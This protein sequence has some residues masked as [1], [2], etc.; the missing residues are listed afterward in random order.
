LGEGAK[1]MSQP[2]V[3]K[4]SQVAGSNHQAEPEVV[5]RAQRR[6]VSEAEKPRILTEAAACQGAGALGAL[7]R[8]EGSYSSY[9]THWRREREAGQLGEQVA[10]KRGRARQAEATE[11]SRLRQANEDLNA[12]LA[13][14][15]P[16]GLPMITAQKTCGDPLGEP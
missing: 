5:V 6:Q 9:L 10:A 8:R 14:A 15:A 7:L 13:Q 3:T 16:R 12:P 11:A 2:K 1:E 4:Q